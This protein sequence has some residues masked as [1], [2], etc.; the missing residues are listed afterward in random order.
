MDPRR[1]S[2]RNPQA[3]VGTRELVFLLTVKPRPLCRASLQKK[4]KP[5]GRLKR[6]QEGLT[7]MKIYDDVTQLVGSTPLVRLQRLGADLPG[8]VLVKLESFNPLSSVKDR[9]GLNMV[10][11]AEKSGKINDQTV[12]VEPTSGN[13]GIA[14]A[15]VCAARG[16]KL[17]LTMPESMSLERRKLLTSLGAELHLTPA[18]GGMGAAIQKAKELSRVERESSNAPT[19]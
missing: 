8:K 11:A 5:A 7:T 10:K 18:S 1:T 12:L 16:Y 14:L 3:L 13:T 6:V 9:I 17:I 4:L 19:I 15:F 2:G